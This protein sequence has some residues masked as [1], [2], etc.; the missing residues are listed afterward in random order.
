MLSA[1]E[2]VQRF[3]LNNDDLLNERPVL[4]IHNSQF[5]IQNF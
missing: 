4:R 2:Q 5:K 1:L 3:Y